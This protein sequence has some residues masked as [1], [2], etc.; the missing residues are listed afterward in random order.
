MKTNYVY[1]GKGSKTIVFIH[2]LSD[3]LNY[4]MKLASH[5]KSEYRILL[6]DIRGHGKS[7]FGDFSIDMLVSD[8]YEL[9]CSEKIEK[10]SLV[11]FSLGGNIALSFAIKYPQ[12]VE[13]LIL[14]AS[15]SQCDENLESKFME[16]RDAL[17]IS[18]EEFYDVIINYVLP[19]DILN[20]HR[21]D[22]EFIKIQQAKNA[23]LK[24]IKAGVDMGFGFNCTG[25]LNEVSAKT[26]IMAGRD[27]VI[28]SLDLAEILNE[29]IRDSRLVI[30][31]NTKHNLLI[32][33]NIDDILQL[34]RQF[35]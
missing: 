25:H 17:D 32:G 12:I 4:W 18:F 9:L 13:R 15:F 24:A 30:F 26:L 8:L 22:L 33:R 3:D 7:E 6:Y 10:A 1:F 27:D 28:V 34:I 19:D 29:N 5:L 31:D 20:R 14:M 23:N 16:F 2:G 21:E 11:G 35:I